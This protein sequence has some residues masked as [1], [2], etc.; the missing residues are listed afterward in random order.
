MAIWPFSI[1]SGLRKEVSELRSSLNNSWM[2]KSMTFGDGSTSLTKGNALTLPAVYAALAILSDTLN[3]PVNVFKED[4]KNK[5]IV[6]DTDPPYEQSVHKLLSKSPSRL[7]TPS[8]WFK[9]MEYSRNIYGN[10]FSYIIRNPRNMIPTALRFLHPDKV[11]VDFNGV[12]NRYTIYGDNGLAVLSNIKAMDMIHLEAGYGGKSPLD[13][14][15]EALSLGKSIQNAGTEYFNEGMTNKVIL[16][17]PGQLSAGAQKNLKESFDRQMKDGRTV[18]LEEGLKPYTLTI[19]PEQRQM[20]E[21]SNASA[22]DVARVF[23]IPPHMLGLSDPTYSNM[24]SSEL[25]F[26]KHNCRPRYRM[27]EQELNWKLLGNSDEYFTK[28]NMNALLRA[29]LKTR[30]ESYGIAITNRWMAPNEARELEDMNPYEGGDKYENPN[31][32]SGAN[33]INDD[34]TEDNGE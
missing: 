31:T 25:S 5:R 10:A 29:D 34:N 23:N 33:D 27:Y 3:I 9:Q 18:T 19:S 30:Y 21:L 17:H 28:F 11:R 22:M 24:E 2:L 16:S 14:A 7:Y 6:D 4:G 26:T 20:L 12:E 13:W 1:I 32:T 8:Q 15:I